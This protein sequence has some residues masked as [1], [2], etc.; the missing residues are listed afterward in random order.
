MARDGRPGGW[1][2]VS[3]PDGGSARITGVFPQGTVAIYRVRF[4]DGRVVEAC[5]DH[6][7]E[8]HHKHWNGKY[9]PGV[10]RAGAARPRILSTLEL[11]ALLAR[12]KGVF[13][14]RLAEPLAKPEAELPV[15]PY[16]L[17]CLLGDGTLGKGTR[18]EFTNPTP[19]IAGNARLPPGLNCMQV[20]PIDYRL[21]CGGGGRLPGGAWRAH[22]LRLAL[23]SL[24]LAGCRSWE[25]HIPPA[26]KEAGIAQRLALL[27]GLMDTDGTVGCPPGGPQLRDQQRAA[28]PGRAGAGVVASSTSWSP[29]RCCAGRRW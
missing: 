11:R 8:V 24:G 17:G 10:S 5:G 28:R 3:T 4:V 20:G 29:R 2:R 14:V 16:V 27:Q 9:R 1:R 23:E 7:W 18:L 26:Y 6:L 21:V 13:S 22:P 12:N 15:D 25:K 19:S